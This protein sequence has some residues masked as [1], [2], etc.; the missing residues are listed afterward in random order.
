MMCFKYKANKTKAHEYIG[1]KCGLL[2]KVLYIN[3]SALK[4][5]MWFAFMLSQIAVLKMA[6]HISDSY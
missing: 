4:R 2:S 3:S 5:V 1:F 6:K